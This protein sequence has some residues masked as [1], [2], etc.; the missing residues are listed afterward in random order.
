MKRR[1]F[2]VVFLLSATVSFAQVE[3]TGVIVE[4][5]VD[6]TRGTFKQLKYKTIVP[7]NAMSFN[8]GYGIPMTMNAGTNQDSWN[9]KTGMGLLFGID[10]KHHFFE[11]TIVGSEEIIVPKMVGIGVGIGVS[12]ISKRAF[13][14]DHTATIHNFTDKDG[15]VCDK[16]ISFKG[17]KEKI[18]LTYLDIPLYLEIGKPSQTKLSGYL[19]VGVKA[20]I[21][22]SEKFTGEGTCAVTG[23]YK[24]IDGVPTNVEITEVEELNY[25][26]EGNAFVENTENNFSKFVLWGS[27]SGGVSI[28][29]SSLDKNK[30]SSCILRLGARLDYSILPIGKEY[31]N[32]N[33]PIGNM[34]GGRMLLLGFDVKLIYCF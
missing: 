27:M 16:R 28:P 3:V 6:T 10:Y 29:F 23:F 26:S 19:D 20:S 32:G 11:T 22:I 21:L 33:T 15:D 1:I 8:A 2:I 18:S 5:K 31:L 13:M 9:K 30:L 34:L 25:H 14:D 7:K 12:H 24:E 17:V 4:G